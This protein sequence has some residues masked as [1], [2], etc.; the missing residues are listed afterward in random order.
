[1]QGRGVMIDLEAHF[2]T[3]GRKV[4][5]DDLMMIMEADNVVVESGDMVLLHSGFGRML[6]EMGGTPDPARVRPNPYAEL[7]G[8]DARLLQWITDSEL[9]ALIADNFAVECD[10]LL[11]NPDDSGPGAR[12]PWL[13]LHEHC[14]FRLGVP[15]AELW[16]LSE[17]ADWLRS[18]GRSR[19][20]LTASPLRIS[21]A[22]GSPVTP[23]AT[24]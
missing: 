13:P 2:S 5:Y 22:V 23:V 4:G 20:L 19:F 12:R 21:G 15:L 9:V 7:N 10:P 16:H 1:M 17:L 14:L 3:T 8:W 11:P 24:V 6:M 18:N